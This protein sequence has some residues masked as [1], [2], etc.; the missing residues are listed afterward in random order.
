MFCY[1]DGSNPNN[2]RPVSLRI[3]CPLFSFISIYDLIL[4]IK[5]TIRNLPCNAVRLL[6]MIHAFTV[7][8]VFNITIYVFNISICYLSVRKPVQ[9]SLNDSF[10]SFR[11]QMTYRLLYKLNNKVSHQFWGHKCSMVLLID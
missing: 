5:V 8:T 10:S 11:F 2:K 3:L 1:A 9:L 6:C 7:V 4:V